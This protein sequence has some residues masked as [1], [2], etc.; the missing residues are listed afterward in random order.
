MDD[1]NVGFTNFA[2]GYTSLA[3]P[4]LEPESV[5]SHE[6]G[7]RASTS[8]FDFSLSAYQNVYKDF[9]ESLALVGFNRQTNLLEFQARNID[10]VEITGVDASLTWFMGES[11]ARLDNWVTRL[12]YSKQN[13][14]DKAS[15]EELDSIMPAQSVLGISYGN[16]DAL[17]RV[18]LATTYSEQAN[19]VAAPQDAPAFFIAPSY[20]LI[21]LLGHY[22]IN[23]DIRIN[24]GVFNIFDKEYY[25]ASEVRGRTR[26]ENLGRFSSPG[27]NFSMNVIVKF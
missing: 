9:I 22:Q 10:E 13:S 4:E 23:D 18:E 5:V 19:E 20:T 7:F 1:V 12:S 16:Y 6:L 17:W 14:E 26:A 27:R 15:G 8:S 11:F 24:A 2:G 3:N 25:L 21:D